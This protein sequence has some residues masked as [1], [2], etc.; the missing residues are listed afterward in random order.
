MEEIQE[1]ADDYHEIRF[2]MLRL[3]AG[4]RRKWKRFAGEGLMPIQPMPMDIH[5]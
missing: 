4:M 2:G 3:K 5:V 1:H